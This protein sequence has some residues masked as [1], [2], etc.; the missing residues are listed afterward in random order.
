MIISQRH[1]IFIFGL[2]LAIPGISLISSESAAFSPSLLISPI[3]LLWLLI[4][5]YKGYSKKIAILFF[6]LTIAGFCSATLNVFNPTRTLFQNAGQEIGYHSYDFGALLRF[7][8]IIYSF[9]VVLTVV[10]AISSRSFNRVSFYSGYLT[11]FAVGAFWGFWQLSRNLVTLPYWSPFGNSWSLNDQ[12]TYF[13][14]FDIHRANGSALEPS[15]WAPLCFFALFCAMEL[16]SNFS[17]RTFLFLMFIILVNL[18]GTLSGTM[19]AGLV[20]LF[21]S[22]IVYN[23]SKVRIITFLNTRTYLYLF[24]FFIFCAGLYLIYLNS[25]A[26][27]ILVQT[28]V[29]QKL[30]ANS[31]SGQAR[32]YILEITIEAFKQNPW[33]GIG[34]GPVVSYNTFA[35][36][37]A[38]GG[39]IAF[40]LYLSI[41]WLAAKRAYSSQS[42]AKAYLFGSF[43]AI[44]TISYGEIF[45]FLSWLWM[46][47]LIPKSNYDNN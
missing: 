38:S 32:G 25:I 2:S 13:G 36:I 23:L 27:Q 4:A 42:Y 40:V 47:I 6:I 15:H 30:S 43:L 44:T 34:W 7:I 45:S 5:N 35:T 9:V 28:S 39:I 46:F 17:R 37:L 31:V 20:G 12:V 3:V 24:S 18:L 41:L 33:F 11:G 22:H 26:L 16:K 8:R 21:L 29:L 19:I 14:G 1:L 10:S